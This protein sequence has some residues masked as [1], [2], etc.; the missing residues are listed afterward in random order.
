MTGLRQRRPLRRLVAGV[1]LLAVALLALAAGGLASL[2]G[3]GDAAHRARALM[4][5]HHEGAAM[6]VPRRL[7]AAVIAT[8]DEHFNEVVVLNVATGIGRAG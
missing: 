3:V 4:I 1:V 6:P 8:E 2:P 5:S 7:A